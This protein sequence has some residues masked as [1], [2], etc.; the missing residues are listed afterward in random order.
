MTLAVPALQPGQILVEVA[1]SGVCHTQLLEARGK[2]GTDRFLPHTLGHEGA[3]VV[4]ATGAGVHKVKPA[5][6]V[7]LSWIKGTGADVP[8]TCYDSAAGRVHSGAI[9]TFMRQTIT[10]ENRV[11]RIPDAM[12]LRQAALLGC[13]IPTG[14][15]IIRHSADVRPGSSVA[16]FGVGGIGLS[17]VMAARLQ[18]A[19]QIIAIDIVTQKLDWA[20]KLGA[21][22]VIDSRYEEPLE[23]IWALTQQRG[24]DYAVEAV[25]KSQ[26]M[27]TAFRAVRDHGGLCVLAG[28]V[29]HGERVALDP[30]DLIRGKKIVGT[31]GG[32]SQ[33]DRDVP[34][35][36][37]LF[38]AGKLPLDDLITHEYRLADINSA[39]RALEQGLV[40]R[41]LIN[42]GTY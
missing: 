18:G 34:I 29:A 4:L 25:G 41:A 21:T 3:G 22:H 39:L 1:Y 38:L 23:A 40:G 28:N 36:V 11:S 42:M 14:A 13:A 2:R 24:V 6:R 27:E 33:L 17:A 37:D 19:E 10:C 20:R 15:G 7:V 8:S 12:P 35:Y 26:T 9:S 5:D 30:F 16:I 32:E 31:W